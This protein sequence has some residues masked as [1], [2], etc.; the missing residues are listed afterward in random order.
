MSNFYNNT[1]LQNGAGNTIQLIGHSNNTGT[2]LEHC[3][4][5]ELREEAA[6][7]RKLLG[8]ERR[9]ILRIIVKLLIWFFSG[10]GASYITAHWLGDSHWLTLCLLTIGVVFPVTALLALSQNAESAFAR[11][12]LSTLRE[13]QF[14]IREKESN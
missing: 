10:G 13:I 12:Q 9:Q 7:R 8:E 11:R 2:P 14:L 6:M 3:S 1:L 5:D 4:V